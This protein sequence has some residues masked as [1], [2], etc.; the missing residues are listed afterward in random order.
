LGTI[1][2]KVIGLLFNN[3]LGTTSKHQVVQKIGNFEEIEA[4]NNNFDNAFG[5]N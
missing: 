5:K 3:T 2:W 1:F 4:K